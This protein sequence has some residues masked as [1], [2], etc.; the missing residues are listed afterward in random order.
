MELLGCSNVAL[1]HELLSHRYDIVQSVLKDS[2]SL[3]IS[4]ENTTVSI[5]VFISFRGGGGGGG[6]ERE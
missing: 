6:G 1:V 3:L 5:S 4:G 2:S